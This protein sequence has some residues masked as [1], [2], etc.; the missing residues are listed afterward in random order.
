MKNKS[1]RERT[2]ETHL[3]HYNTYRVGIVNC[4]KQLD[5]IMP[6]ITAV[7]DYIKGSSFYIANSTEK[8]AIDRI[9][10]KRALDLYEEI[11][12]YK[13]IIDSIDNAFKELKP[14]EQDF[15]KLRYFD[16]EPMHEVKRVMGY[17]E[18]KSLYRIRRHVLEK[19]EI[20]LKNL[21]KN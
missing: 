20:S 3:R 19:L 11:Q 9:E 16:C 6:N 10:S 21:L 7:Y 1:M 13:I 14:H 4:Q 2:L 17:S 18:E 5:Y 15:V 12:N 8:I